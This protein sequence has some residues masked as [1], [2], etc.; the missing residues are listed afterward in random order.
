MNSHDVNQHFAKKR[1]ETPKKQ[2]F[3]LATALWEACETEWNRMH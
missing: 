2:D 3:T 1:A